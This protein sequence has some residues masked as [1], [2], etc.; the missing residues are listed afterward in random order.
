MLSSDEWNELVA[1]KN[2]ISYNP[3]NVVPEKQELFTQLLIKSFET[4]GQAFIDSRV[5]ILTK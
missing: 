3:A 1:L 4:R 5:L 2:E